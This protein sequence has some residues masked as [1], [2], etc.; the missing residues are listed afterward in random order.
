MNTPR[1]TL[2]GLGPGHPSLLTRQAWDALHTADEIYL[3]TRQHPVVPAL[4]PRLTLHSFDALYEQAENFEQ[5]Y[6]QIIEKILALGTRPGGVIY[7]VPG[8]PF[9]AETTAPEIYRRARAMGGEVRVLPGVSFLEAV[10]S[11]LGVDLFPRLSLW[12]AFDLIGGHVPPFPPDVPAIIAQIHSSHMAS[13]VKL[14]LTSL[15]PDEHPVRLVHAAGTDGQVMEDIPL[16]AI[17]HS[18][19]T[20]LLTTLY[21]PPLEP[22]TSV[23]SFMEIVARLRAPDGCPWDREQTHRSLRQHLLEETCEVL[24]ALDTE[25]ERALAE[26]LGDLLFQIVFHAQIASETG[27]FN[28]TDVVRGIGRK[29]IHRHPHVFGGVEV[30]GVADVLRNWEQ[31]KA[32]ER[33][34]KGQ[35]P[36]AALDGVLPGLPALAQ[37]SALQR[38]ASRAGFDW[39]KI[40]EVYAKLAEELEELRAAGETERES[41]LGDALFVLAHLANW[42]GI[43]PEDALR[44][45]NLRFRRR[46]GFVEE[47]ARQAGKPVAE[48]SVAELNVFWDEAKRQERAA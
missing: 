20:G 30:A 10:T 12:D 27:G 23:E 29:L 42:Y 25:D 15:Y 7:A 22:Q 33:A 8:H 39:E 43:N 48:F 21:L 44:G 18:P 17:D 41:E 14:T 16:H 47:S 28:L 13:E 11:A 45:A 40:E 5:V 24:D 9:I 38:K 19:H 4:P 46:F 35:A 1:I 26:E 31:I 36:Q 37:A 6:S 32:G 2:L 3:R 34:A